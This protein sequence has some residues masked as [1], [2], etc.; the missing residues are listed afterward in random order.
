MKDDV[1]FYVVIDGERFYLFLGREAALKARDEMQATSTKDVK[2]YI[3]E[4]YL[5]NVLPAH[6]VLHDSKTERVVVY[7]PRAELR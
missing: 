6:K 1:P 4:Q 7:D 2:A 3:V 5:F